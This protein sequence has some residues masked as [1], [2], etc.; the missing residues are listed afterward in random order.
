VDSLHAGNGEGPPR[1]R[2]PAQDSIRA[3]GNDYLRRAFPRLDFIRRARVVR[4]WR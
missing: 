2:G 4:E 3:S 1:G